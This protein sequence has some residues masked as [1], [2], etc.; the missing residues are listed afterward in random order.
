MR[1]LTKTATFA[2]LH[3]SVG[4]GVSYALTGSVAIA[5]GVALIEAAEAGKSVTALVELK[6]RFDEAANIKWARD[7]ERAGVQV[8][9]DPQR[10]ADGIAVRAGP[11]GDD[12]ADHLVADDDRQVDLEGERAL[13]EMDVGAADR[14]LADADEHVVEAGPGNVD[15]GHCH[16]G[17][18]GRLDD[19]AHLGCHG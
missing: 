15:L 12:P 16:A 17:G 13:P 2:A 11:H 14:G 19:C 1:D 5:T 18:A 3:F 7:L 9:V 6:A 4:F 10:L 8:A